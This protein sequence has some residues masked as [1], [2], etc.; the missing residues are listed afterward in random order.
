[1]ASGKYKPSYLSNLFE[2][3]GVPKPGSEEEL[4]AKWSAASLYTGGADTVSSKQKYLPTFPT[5]D[6]D[7]LRLS[8][9]LHVSSLLWGYIQMSSAE[10]KM[11][12]NEFWGL[13]G[14]RKWRTAPVFPTSM[15]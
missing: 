15:P 2:T 10:H 7:G 14:Y 4:I 3:Q 13:D 6:A 1:M 12:L 9:L 5:S 8:H 11:K